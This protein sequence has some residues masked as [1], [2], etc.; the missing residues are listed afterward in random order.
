MDACEEPSMPRIRVGFTAKTSRRLF[1]SRSI[2]HMGGEAA[3]WPR[4]RST[5]GLSGSSGTKDAVNNLTAS[6]GAVLNFLRASCEALLNASGSCRFVL[7][8]CVYVCLWDKK[9]PCYY[10][11]WFHS[12]TR[13]SPSVL[14]VYVVLPSRPLLAE[15]TRTV[16]SS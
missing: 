3:S 9:C 6:G 12:T 2:C 11:S 5:T 8:P 7:C 10:V 13:L 14:P 15:T 1:C 4:W 16:H